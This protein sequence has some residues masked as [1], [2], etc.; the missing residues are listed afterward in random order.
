MESLTL[1]PKG[2]LFVFAF[3]PACISKADQ[4]TVMIS[5]GGNIRESG[6][7]Y[8]IEEKFSHLNIAPAVKRVAE[9]SLSCAFSC[10]RNLACFSFNFA[11]FPDQA[12]KFTCEI[13]SSD[14]YNNSEKFLPS[15]TFHHFSVLSPCSNLPCRNKGKCVTLYETNSYVCACKKIFTGKHCENYTCPP[16]FVVHGESCYYVSPSASTWNNSRGF[17]QTFG[18]DL[19]VIK[20]EDENQFFYHLLRSTSN[21]LRDG[22]I[23][24]YRKADNK[25]YWLDDRPAEGNYQRWGKG[26][27]SGGGE[28][29]VHL[30]GGDSGGT[31]NDLSCLTT[32]PVAICQWPI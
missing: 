30:R 25:F 16:G 18:A 31:W 20:S 28:N 12:G 13:L 19:A 14:K 6:F 10:L 22:W 15:K 32:Y 26:E 29:C 17:C 2:L 21:V 7:A 3:L 9:N 23:G 1:L 11:A 8:F 24:L 4:A 27:P 5:R